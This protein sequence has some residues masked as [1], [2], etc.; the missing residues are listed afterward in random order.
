MP[1]TMSLERRLL[2]KAYGAELVLTPG[3]DGMRGAVEKAESLADEYQD[4]FV[5]S[6]SRTRPTL[7]PTGEQPLKRSGVTLPGRLTF[8]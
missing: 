8:L 7:K 2:L 5:P 6:N 1:E 4:A 3:P